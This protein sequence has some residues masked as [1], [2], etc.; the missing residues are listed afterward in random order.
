MKKSDEFIEEFTQEL[1]DEMISADLKTEDD[2]VKFF[3]HKL[4]T[5]EAENMRLRKAL[6][7]IPEP[8]EAGE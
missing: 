2:I 7:R 5:Q 1:A 8:E 6:H 4:A 3:I